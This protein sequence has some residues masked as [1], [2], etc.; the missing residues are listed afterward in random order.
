MHNKLFIMILSLVAVIFP[1]SDNGIYLIDQGA[2]F[3]YHKGTKEAS[4]PDSAWTAIDF[5]DSSWLRGKIPFFSNEKITDGSELIDMKG[6]Y[7][8]VYVRRKFHIKDPS[9]LGSLSLEIKADDGY[10]A[11]L[12]GI[13]IASLH[14]PSTPRLRYSS[15]SSKTNREPIK[16]DETK[17]QNF[18][19]VTEKGW[20]VLSVMLL[21]YSR[22][23]SDAFLDV[24]LS[25]VKRELVPPKITSISPKPG[26]VDNL[27]SITI[28]FSEP[29][30]GIDAGDLIINNYPA[31]LVDSKDNTFTFNLEKLASGTINVWWAP[32]HG[33]GDQASPP[34]NFDPKIKTWNYELLDL[35]APNLSTRLPLEGNVKKFSQ[36]EIW[37]DEPVQ[38]VEAQDL[39][40]NGLP[41]DSVSGYGA[42][43]YIFKFSEIVSGKVK[44][45]WTEDANITDFNRTP[46]FF[47]GRSWSIQVDNDFIPDDVVISEFSAA[48]GANYKRVDGD[49]IELLN[50]GSN[51]VNL[52]GWALTDDRNN[53]AKW[54]FPETI[55][56]AEK[57][58]IV[59]A[60]GEDKKNDPK[61]LH[62]NF[63]LN[64]GGE[65]LALSRPETPRHA[66][67]SIKFP[68]QASGTSYG[69]N[70]EN[71]WV[72]FEKPTPKSNNSSITVN[73]RVKPVHFN[74]PRGF[75][76]KK[77]VYLTLSTETPG[78][79]IRYTTNGDTP[80]C[81]GDSRYETAG[82]VYTSPIRISKTSTIRAVAYKKGM[83]S[84]KV[85][86]HTY[87]YGLTTNRKRLP[88][89]SLVTDDRH[90]WGSKGIQKQPNAQK[91]GIAWE[92][93]ISAELIRPEDNG[94]FAVDCGIRIQGG[95]YVRPRY[96]PNGG[97]PFS[98]F[99][100]RLYFRGDYGTGRLEY[101]LFGNT[102]VQS[103]DRIVLRAGMNDHTSPFIKDEWARRLCIN[104]GIVTPKGTFVNLYI[105]GKY[106]GYYNPTERIDTKFLADWYQTDENYD[107]IAQFNE[108]RAGST[109]AWRK[110]LNYASRYDM[111]EPKYFQKVE[112]QLD[113]TAM[114][115]YLL[116]LIY[117]NNDDWPHNNWR[118][119][120][121]K[122][123]GK[124]RFICWDAEWAFSNSSHNTIK[125]QLST[126]NP[127][128]GD[129]EI[130]KLFNALKVSPEFQ[131]IFADQVHKH[132]YNGGALTNTEIRNT[133]DELYNTVRGTVSGFSKNWGL[134]WI[135]RRRSL[136]LA[137]LKEANLAAS[138]QAPKFNQFGGKVP[139]GFSLNMSASKGD[140]YYTTDGSDPR[141]KFASSIS[142]NAKKFEKNKEVVLNKGSHIKARTLTGNKWSAL[143]SAKFQI[144]ESAVPMRITE[145]MYNP[146]G[147]DAF[148]FIEFQ[149]IGDSELNLSGF[150]MEGVSFRFA[151]N[152]PNLNAG[153][154]ILLVNDANADAFRVRYPG[155]VIN[156]FYEGNLSNRGERLALIDRNGETVISVDYND[157]GNWPSE[158]DGDGYSLVLS[159]QDGDPDAPANWRLSSAKGGTPGRSSSHS[160]EPLVLINEILAEN[161]STIKNGAIFSDYIELKNVADTDVY[162]QNW[163]LSDN[164]NKPRKF[165]FPAG[166]VIKANSYLTIWM[167]DNYEASGLH[168][169][170]AMDK[171]GDS[172][173]L[174]N[175]AGERIDVVNFG[176]QLA[177]YSIG[178]HE[179][180]WK[181]NHPT[182]GKTN[183]NASLADL[184]KLRINEFVAAAPPGGNDWIELYNTD[185]KP[186]A[187]FGLSW[188]I[189]L[190]KFTYRRLSFISPKSY[191]ILLADEKPG[192]KH[193]DFRLPAAGGTILIRNRHGA[194]LDDVSYRTQN[195]GES[196]GRYPNGNGSWTTFTSTIS[197]G[198]ANY[199]PITDGLQINEILAINDTSVIDPLGRS[200]DWIEVWNNS[201]KS[202][203][204]SGMSLSINKI[205][206]DQWDFP[207]G[208]ILNSKDRLLIWCNG[209]R[210]P[211]IGPKDYLNT[212]ISLDGKYGSV[213]LFNS[214]EQ[215]IDSVQYGFQI[216]NTSI[217]RTKNGEWNLLQIPSPGKSNE[218]PHQTATASSITINEWTSGGSG[219]D[220]IELH[221]TSTLPIDLGGNYLS[222]DLSLI[223]RTKFE[224]P[225]LNFIDA[226]GF[227][228]WI[229]DGNLSQGA[230]HLNF[231]ISSLGE[232]IA[233]YSSSKSLIEKV[234]ATQISPGE[235][236]GR[237]PD[238]ANNIVKFPTTTSPGKPNYKPIES[239]VIN[240]VLT[241]TDPPYEDAIEL[242]NLSGNP[243][244]IGNWWISNSE[245]YLTKFQIPNGTII[246]PRGTL[247]F[248]EGQ[249]NTNQDTDK[250]FALNSSQGDKVILS[251]TD[252]NGKLTGYRIPI[253]FE[254]AENGFSFGR[255]KTSL[256]DQFVTLARPTFGVINPASIQSFRQGTGD[257]NSEHKIGPIVI[258]EVM[259][260]PSPLPFGAGTPNDEFIEL[261]NITNQNIKL[262]D[263]LNPLNTWQIDGGVKFEFP[264]G[265]ELKPNTYS[266]LVEFD[267]TKES[268][269]AERF[270]KRYNV[271][272]DI[273]LFGPMRG[274]LSNGGDFIKLLKPDTPQ[275]I[276]REDAGYVPY[277][278]V[279]KVVFKDSSPWPIEP[280]GL[281][282]TLQR[283]SGTAFGNDPIN[284][285]ASAPNPGRD[286]KQA[287]GDDSD[288]DGIPDIWEI[289]N[290]LDPLEATDATKDTDQ[291][292][293]SNLSEFYVGTDPQNAASVFHLS[294]KL[295]DKRLI[296]LS[297]NSAYNGQLVELQTIGQIG[298]EKWKTVMEWNTEDAGLQQLKVDVSDLNAQF[299]RLLHVE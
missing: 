262:Y 19:G 238:G 286:N 278:L 212:G 174:F 265:S 94:G 93:P 183:S 13:E 2:I 133:Y 203:D 117:A 47:S 135:N 55:I 4:S 74:L 49:W 87:F 175:P 28:T 181:L 102:P 9:Q 256:G 209:S 37:F 48:S 5:D 254:A 191:Q 291:D 136:V 92:R 116:P 81:C 296:E 213:Y 216:S 138:D 58:I 100:F 27:D 176:L 39:M 202:I 261:R 277:I 52:K 189:G 3:N 237:L 151:E 97:L 23:N 184:K 62:T 273:N 218:I 149:N 289:A 89:L 167:N 31:A 1:R 211:E 252:S 86:T 12:N 128:W 186:A 60:T 245:S 50:R 293:L 282:A 294:A 80:A 158:A 208:T 240:E 235:S 219:N 166:V 10:V 85:K 263:P 182:P 141:V 199:R 66:I 121:H 171:D 190:G 45:T 108:I 241:H 225:E 107:L 284:W 137:H 134:N 125:N 221:N 24:R 75:Y 228:K 270:I 257:N 96:N 179:D 56:E 217:G 109:T 231:S 110:L 123:D 98:K 18:S 129:A 246:Q 78:A 165:N 25:A 112:E 192:V 6:N 104:S 264:I 210:D 234:E 260:H 281:G 21:N 69:L 164:P 266:L 253:E 43:P 283:K 229:A 224:I 38:G 139:A 131:M 157:G 194:E 295:I 178:R 280:D 118:V 68:E 207:A 239:I 148:E 297:F 251:A 163:S 115:N 76:E 292:G 61:Q 29:M 57:R 172:I 14:K 65:Y 290:G 36:A 177:D 153:D 88:A 84:S 142:N 83:L 243:L 187:L 144:G 271:P 140:I 106:K 274:N 114:A 267:P 275:G 232:P 91:H 35:I 222:D 195:D 101:P 215:I 156:G 126:L 279:D 145:I 8:T 244:N 64:P 16:W 258:H 250:S 206:P 33:I 111:D 22:S 82:N 155:T 169:G 42:G 147:G 255:I 132:F 214:S 220:W 233:I 188:E 70:N 276:D 299:F 160:P 119:A 44:L 180:G 67:S 15:R 71:E 249:F 46:N 127:P 120:R 20:N 40:A 51:D 185:D 41:A 122:S 150:S 268:E 236:Q 90:L 59:F 146:Q 54:I 173:A 200:S 196:L 30:S 248:Y 99:S 53:M 170:F 198:Q 79:E 197:P 105:N 287:E 124:F 32:E 242:L 113:I 95:G 77:A 11:W 162:L 227:V 272:E 26:D 288:N 205:D 17:L 230:D 269:I 159:N 63:K 161:I 168:A 226:G 298:R 130:A 152:S 143:T 72:Y 204:L 223:G 193:L 259:Y 7:S 154:Y 247:A 34:N 103:F 285:K 73:G 201:N